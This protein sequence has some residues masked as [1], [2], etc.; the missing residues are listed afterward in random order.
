MCRQALAK[1]AGRRASWRICSSGSTLFRP[2]GPSGKLIVWLDPQLE[3]P[4][5]KN[6]TPSVP[7]A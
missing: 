7:G 4:L 5:G 1:V 3:I 6:L 2:N